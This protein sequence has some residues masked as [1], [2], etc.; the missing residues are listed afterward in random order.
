MNTLLALITLD[1]AVR[2]AGVLHFV[3]LIASAMVPKVFN[4][5]QALS[6]VP[7]VVRSLF[8]MYST[9]IVL[10]II[11]MGAVTLL[12]AEAMAQGEPVARS[13]AAFIAVFW[14]GRLWVKWFVFDLEPYLTRIWLKIGDHAL[15]V[16]FVYFVAVYGWAALRWF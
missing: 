6:P 12:H 13:V 15:A 4:L 1:N 9:F 5:K 14:L 8:W 11:G 3:V 7:P 10:T 2:L 16:A